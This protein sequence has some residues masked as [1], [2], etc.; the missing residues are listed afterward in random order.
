[1]LSFERVCCSCGPAV[2]SWLQEMAPYVKSLDPNHLLTIGE[3][4]F[5]A[6]TNPRRS[7]N[8]QGANSCVATP[9]SSFITPFRPFEALAMCVVLLMAL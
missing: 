9:P 2:Q 1:M 8:P 6:S 4:G 7:F 3:E 5:Y